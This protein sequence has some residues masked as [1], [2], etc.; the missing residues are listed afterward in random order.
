MSVLKVALF[1]VYVCRRQ[2]PTFTARKEPGRG[3]GP[4]EQLRDVSSGVQLLFT[5]WLAGILQG[6]PEVET[7]VPQE[8]L[9]EEI[10]PRGA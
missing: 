10:L 3:A 9:Q 7:S 6:R 8:G 1:L 4:R 2:A 5:A